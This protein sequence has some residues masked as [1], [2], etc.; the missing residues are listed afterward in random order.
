MVPH[1]TSDSDNADLLVQT[2]DK[3]AT[4]RG[5]RPHSR[6]LQERLQLRARGT[7]GLDKLSKMSRRSL[8]ASFRVHNPR[9]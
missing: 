9:G 2:K 1:G 8:F 5:N 6:C 4:V 3:Q 7:E